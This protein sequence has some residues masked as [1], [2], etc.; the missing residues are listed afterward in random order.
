M[1]RPIVGVTGKNGGAHLVY[2][3][4]KQIPMSGVLTSELFLSRYPTNT[5]NRNRARAATVFK[6]FLDEDIGA[7]QINELDSGE[8]DNP[9]MEDPN[10][11]HCHD[12]M[13]PVASAFHNWH[14]DGRYFPYTFKFYSNW[15]KGKIII[16]DRTGMKPAG[17]GDMVV[18]ESDWDNALQIVAKEIVKDTRKYRSAVI[19]TLYNGLLGE[20]DNPSYFR[21]LYDEFEAAGIDT[22]NM[23][24]LVLALIKHQDYRIDGVSNLG[25][26]GADDARSVRLV[27]AETMS[28]RL[29]AT[30][31][32]HFSKF[33]NSSLKVLYGGIDSD[34]YTKRFT[35]ISG[36]S[37]ALTESMASEMS[38]R[39]VANDFRKEI[40][41]RLLFPYV[42]M[43]DQPESA[44]MIARIK[45]NLIHLHYWLLQ[46]GLTLNDSELAFTYQLFKQLYD[47]YKA[48]NDTSLDETCQIT[49]ADPEYYKE[50]GGYTFWVPENRR[51]SSDENYTL[52]AWMGVVQYLMLDSEFLH[53]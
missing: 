48:D 36:V 34:T 43:T 11:T 38:C 52:K 37:E 28:R 6:Y 19:R 10:C 20:Y 45:E 5:S 31:K 14:D 23:R 35:Q 2:D 17:Y 49:G 30:T 42:E 26:D 3:E 46:E 44:E 8:Y 18:P 51:F 13:D 40:N 4:S 9:V 15:T 7:S 53:E 41:E 25:E 29:Y 39:G 47:S 21:S 1:T 12:R 27:T 24:E 33:N 16:A 32:L 22:S 50:L